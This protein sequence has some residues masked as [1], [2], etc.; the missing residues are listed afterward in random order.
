MT[1]PGVC[2]GAWITRHSPSVSPP[3]QRTATPQAGP[4][5]RRWPRRAS[6]PGGWTAR[7]E[8]VPGRR[9]TAKVGG[10]G[11]LV[12]GQPDFRFADVAEAGAPES[13]A[14]LERL[15]EM[16]PQSQ[17]GKIAKGE[18]VEFVLGVA[19]GV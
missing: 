8:P 11:E 17:V 4:D 15:P 13:V 7:E 14:D 9:V 19:A 18:A 3:C 16:L 12:P 5:S 10:A 6:P 1:W 2:P